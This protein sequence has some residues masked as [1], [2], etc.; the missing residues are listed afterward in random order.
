MKVIEGS[1]DWDEGMT[2]ET[3]G[4]GIFNDRIKKSESA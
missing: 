3:F 1:Y 2:P 4:V